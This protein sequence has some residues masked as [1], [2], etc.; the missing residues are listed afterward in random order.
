MMGLGDVE[1]SLLHRLSLLR[2]GTAR[3][4]RSMSG[5]A[6]PSASRLADSLRG[7]R[8][9]AVVVRYDGR[10]AAGSQEGMRF[11]LFVACEGLRGGSEAR[12]GGDGVPGI[13]CLLD[14]L[15]GGLSRTLLSVGCRMTFVGEAIVHEDDRL[16]VAQ[17]T[18]DLEETP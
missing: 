2:I 11:S 4:F 18:Y 15:R 6:E 16:I 10:R 14:L 12:M 9:P 13:H 7:R 8:Q 3:A 17:Q 5:A 1:R